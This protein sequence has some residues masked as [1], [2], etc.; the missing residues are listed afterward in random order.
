VNKSLYEKIYFDQIH[1]EALVNNLTLFYK[2]YVL[3]YLLCFR[4]VHIVM[5]SLYI[6]L[7]RSHL[8]YASEVWNPKSVTMI[9][10]LERV[11]RRACTY[12]VV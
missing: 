9:K 10:L 2:T 12:Y 6:A 11:Q 5:K 3:P 8:E 7:V 4:G 1:C